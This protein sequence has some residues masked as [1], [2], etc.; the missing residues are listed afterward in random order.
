MTAMVH[1]ISFFNDWAYNTGR[2]RAYSKT[3]IILLKAP[4]NSGVLTI[5]TLSRT[6]DRPRYGRG[7]IDLY[8][9]KLDTA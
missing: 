7:I 9:Y 2:A 8:L 3:I 6:S 4:C 5:G 1:D